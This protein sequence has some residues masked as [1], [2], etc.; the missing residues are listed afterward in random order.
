MGQLSGEG[1]LGL[2]L[3]SVRSNNALL[4]RVSLSFINHLLLVTLMTTSS[5]D[6]GCAL[7]LPFYR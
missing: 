5:R 1:T 2:G 6:A 3:E 4:L 7:F